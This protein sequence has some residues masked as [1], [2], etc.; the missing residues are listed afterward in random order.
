MW[1]KVTTREATLNWNTFKHDFFKRFE[2]LKERDLFAKITR[3][4]QKGVIDEY[5]DEWKA[6]VTHVPKLTY[7]QCLQTYGYELKPYIR[8]ELE[9]LNVS[10]MDKVRRKEKII[11][12]KIKTWKRNHD[13]DRR[14]I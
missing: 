9:L 13:K 12:E 8:D 14:F 7:T 2:D 11:E 1:W 5:I 4:Q 10:T 3:L 6:L